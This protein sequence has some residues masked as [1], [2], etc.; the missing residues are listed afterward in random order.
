[1]TSW[2]GYEDARGWHAA[3]FGAMTDEEG[4]YFEAEMAAAHM[5]VGPGVQV[6]DIGFGNGSFLGWCRSRGATPHGTEVNPR[7]VQ[8][9]RSHGY[10]CA[11]DPL[12]VHQEAG[13]TPYDLITAFDVL[14]HI[15]R[16]TLVEFVAQIRAVCHPDTLVLLRFPNGDN[17][18]A[19]PL[20]NGD[21]T[22]VTAIGQTMVH[23]VATLAGF[24][25]VRIGAPAQPRRPLGLKRA[26]IALGLPLRGAI[27]LVV[28]HLFM[29][30][31]PVLFSANLL[32]TL[33]PA[34]SAR[35]GCR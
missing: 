22:H 29:G 21:V 17:P 32:V 13:G 23:Q 20:Q 12:Q 35:E 26:L 33:R 11:T 8:R 14:E 24:D 19:L 31:A 3:T 7:L 5:A 1:M 25:L 18:F 15:E 27:G 10:L 2:A 9:A 28:R 16:D 6:L 4:R 34:R 30:G